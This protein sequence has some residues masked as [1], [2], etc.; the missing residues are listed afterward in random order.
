MPRTFTPV[1]ADE[2]Q[3]MGSDRRLELVCGELTE[4]TPVGGPHSELTALL[5]SWLVPFV[6]KNKLGAVGTERGFI[7][8]RDPDT[9]RAPDVHF[10]S[11]QRIAGREEGFF[12]GAPDLAVEV[13]SPSDRASD[14]QARI[15]DYLAAGTRL[16]WLVDPQNETVT[17][18]H[19]AGDARI[20]SG[21][22]PVEGEDVLPGFSF[23]PT[24]VFR[25]D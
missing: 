18:Y 25:R 24:D 6:R 2:L 5:C 7:L 10:I 1:S 19:P 17:V 12:L 16:V 14:V 9:V 23:R 11:R 20:R 8:S 15:R 22:Q 21:E 4:M 13:V 3:Q